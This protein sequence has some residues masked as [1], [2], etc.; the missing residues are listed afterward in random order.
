M[1]GLR[2]W[3]VFA[4]VVRRVVLRVE[5]GGK[6]NGERH[7]QGEH[8]ANGAGYLHVE[9]HFTLLMSGLR[10]GFRILRF[11]VIPWAFFFIWTPSTQDQIGGVGAPGEIG[12]LDYGV[13]AS[14]GMTF[15]TRPFTAGRIALREFHSYLTEP[16]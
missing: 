7:K 6:A 3:F 12:G 14:L 10:R 15:T 13:R 2:G 16:S 1:G 8:G 9:S 11:P 4:A 5:A